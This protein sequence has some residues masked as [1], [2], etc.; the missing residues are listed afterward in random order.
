MLRQSLLGGLQ[1]EL[2]IGC[3]Q[4]AH[5][6]SFPQG[7][8]EDPDS[9]LHPLAT[10]AALYHY[11]LTDAGYDRVYLLGAPDREHANQRNVPGGEGQKN[12]PHYAEL[13]AAL[14]AA[15]Y[16]E[17]ASPTTRNRE[18][19]ATA[20][21]EVNWEKLPSA[22]AKIV[23]QNI[24]AFTTVCMLHARFL[25]KALDARKHAGAAWER[26]MRKAGI[27]MLGGQEPELHELRDFAERY[28]AWAIDVQR[29]SG[30]ELFTFDGA[31]RGETLG[32]V[33]GKAALDEPYHELMLR[34]NK[35]GQTGQHSAV[36]WY[37]AALSKAAREFCEANYPAWWR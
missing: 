16:F 22:N 25:T 18:V 30:V 1:E 13:G 29:Y 10:Q 17:D 3:V 14:A 9:A 12:R 2:T 11:A 23:Q 34:L 33:V 28:L 8:P 24:V 21:E 36:G 32:R 37:V 35:V 20:A 6:F 27:P 31:I 4:L 5:Y 19:Y 26:R 15:H 7:R